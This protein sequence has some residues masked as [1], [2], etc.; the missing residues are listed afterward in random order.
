[1]AR[2]DRLGR[3]RRVTPALTVGS[4]GGSSALN[5]SGGINDFTGADIERWECYSIGGDGL[6]IGTGNPTQNPLSNYS[7]TING[8]NAGWLNSVG[9]ATNMTSSSIFMVVLWQ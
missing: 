1:M 4:G 3:Q 6:Y 9:G 2:R 5:Y 7:I 8:G